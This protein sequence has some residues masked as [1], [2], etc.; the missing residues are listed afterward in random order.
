MSYFD[1][2]LNER[3]QAGESPLVAWH[4]ITVLTC[5]DSG[6]AVVT[7]IESTNDDNDD[8][9]PD[10]EITRW[11]YTDSSLDRVL[12]RVG[13]C[14]VGVSGVIVTVTLDGKEIR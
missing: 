1:T 8:G 12:A 11:D 13:K 10:G 7:V 14:R 3:I 4:N 6:D 9:Y 5:V 2:K